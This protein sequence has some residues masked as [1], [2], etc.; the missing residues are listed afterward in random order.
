MWVGRVLIA[1][2]EGHQ[3]TE[4]LTLMS[5]G[6]NAGLRRVL[7]ATQ[8]LVFHTGL[9]FRKP[10]FCQVESW[11]ERTVP[12]N[13]HLLANLVERHQAKDENLGPSRLTV[14]PGPTW[15]APVPL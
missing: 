6:H 11:E 2:F 7:K 15:M 10:T 13:V 1:I 5:G 14:G 3:F 9:P 12:V 8:D 4:A